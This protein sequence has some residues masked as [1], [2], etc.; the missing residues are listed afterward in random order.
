VGEFIDLIPVLVTV[1][2]NNPRKMIEYA[3]EKLEIASKHNINFTSL[4]MYSAL[5]NNWKQTIQ[6]VVPKTISEQMLLFN[7]RGKRSEKEFEISSQIRQTPESHGSERIE[8]RMAS[9]MCEVFYTSDTIHFY[10]SSAFKSEM[11]QIEELL[12]KI[13][14]QVTAS[15][16]F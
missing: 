5:Q 14:E 16:L 1:D 8:A 2:E 9:M 7:F 11:G 3:E 4:M 12:T 13:S 6:N 15:L 10:I